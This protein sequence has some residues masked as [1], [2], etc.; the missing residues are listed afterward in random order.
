MNNFKH[1][2]LTLET[3]Y[4]RPT[5]E[6]TRQRILAKADQLIR[7]FGLT[8]TTVSDIAA[9]LGMSPANIYK[10]FPSKDSIIEASVEENLAELRMSIDAAVSSGSGTLARIE[11]LVLAIFRWQKQL[12]CDELR[13]FG[14]LRLACTQRW[15]CVRD[16]RKFLLQKVTAIIESGART[17]EFDISELSLPPAFCSTAWQSPSI[18]QR[19]RTLMTR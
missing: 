12:A 2:L 6:Q 1:H 8:K 17:G 16:F 11:R 19:L 4:Q 7:H 10:F 5:S 13:R 9:G 3:L 14:A 15:K 18:P